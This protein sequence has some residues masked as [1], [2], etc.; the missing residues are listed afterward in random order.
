MENNKMTSNRPYAFVKAIEFTLPWEC[1]R[2]KDGSLK[3]DGGLNYHDEGL[4][5]KYGIYK[6]AN[7]EV[8]VENLTLE[9]AIEIYK[10]KYWDVYIVLKP[11]SANLDHL[12]TALAVAVFDA[13][14]NCGPHR[15]I[16]W[17]GKALENKNP[18]RILNDLRGAY[19]FDL[20]SSNKEKHFKNYKGWMN[21]L[22]DLKKLCDVLEAEDQAKFEF[23]AKAKKAVKGWESLA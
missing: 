6:K 14:V 2:E 1:G 13:G 4:P 11:V 21:R 10:K 20:V 7:P 9:Q 17:L 19:Y 12:P 16:R 8:D 18:A 23:N 5:T 3:K 15:A 22:T